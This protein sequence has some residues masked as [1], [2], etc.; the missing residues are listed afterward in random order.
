MVFDIVF[1]GAGVDP[2]ADTALADA[3]RENGRVWLAAERNQWDRETESSALAA[4]SVVLPYEPLRL[5]AAG[6]GLAVV[7]P[8]DDF[9]IRRSW[10]GPAA[11]GAPAL[12]WAVAE[13]IGFHPPRREWLRYLG[14]PLAL[15]HVG[16]SAAL[17]Q[18]EVPDEFFRDRV[19]VVG[20]RPMVG[21]FVERR[22]E[23]R[24]PLGRFAFGRV[25]MP[26]VEV[27]ATQMVNLIRGDGLRRPPPAVEAVAM[28]LLTVAAAMGF[29]RMRP[30]PILEG[31]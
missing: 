19:V 9:M 12:T 18:D 13:G 22:D 5:A 31:S 3:F 8:E 23:F 29:G 14:G 11:D 28:F 2:L 4:Q 25:F 15:P 30:L 6:W 27:H 16:F 17:R 1:S 21:G 10:L 7:R 24:N 20:A 26:A